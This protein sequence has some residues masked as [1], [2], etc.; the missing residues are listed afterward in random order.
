VVVPGTPDP[1]ELTNRG[2]LY[3]RGAGVVA[4]DNGALGATE[5]YFPGASAG[6]YPPPWMAPFTPVDVTAFTTVNQPT[7]ASFVQDAA[8][9]TYGLLT[10][11]AS[12][13][14][15]NHAMYCQAGGA[16]HFEV[17]AA[18]IPNWR[19]SGT[20]VV[21][22]LLRRSS[23]GRWMRFGLAADGSGNRLATIADRWTAPT[24][25][26]TGTYGF[27][28]QALS[29]P[30]WLRMA[31]DGTNI[32]LQ[33]SQDGRHWTDLGTDTPAN[34]GFSATPPNQVGVFVVANTSAA[35]A[36]VLVPS[37]QVAALA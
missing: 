30:Y 1:V 22:I 25:Y 2:R 6:A 17:V 24:T 13:G 15:N 4:S 3:V 14:S 8:V 19:S 35:K 32:I 9:G 26:D 21:G 27:E 5:L 12:V 18:F 37:F 7:G 10:S 16:A 28:F 33:F 29:A 20:P 31:Y 23:D 36:Q 11:P 34:Y